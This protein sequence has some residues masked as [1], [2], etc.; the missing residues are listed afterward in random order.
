MHSA[1]KFY[2]NIRQKKEVEEKK[3]TEEAEK[4]REAGSTKKEEVASFA[5][6]A[7]K[8]KA[9]KDKTELQQ[10]ET[11]MVGDEAKFACDRCDFMGNTNRAVKLHW[12]KKHRREAQEEDDAKVKGKEVKQVE[13]KKL[14]EDLEKTKKDWQD[15]YDEDGNPLDEST[16]ETTLNESEMETELTQD[17]T[18]STPKTKRRQY[19]NDDELN[20]KIAELESLK[21][22]MK[23][24]EELLNI[25][26][27]KIASLEEQNI[28]KTEKIEKSDKIFDR[29]NEKMEE[30]KKN[31]K[32]DDPKLRKELNENNK[33]INN[34]NQRLSENLKKIRDESNL[35]AKAEADL[36][37]KDST[38]ECLKE[39]LAK[40]KSAS[41]Q[42][43]SGRTPS[44]QSS[45][46][47]AQ[48]RRSELCRDFQRHGFC[49]R[50]NKCIFFH[51]P[52]RNQP[53]CQPDSSMK[54]DC[55]YWLEGYCRKDEKQCRGKHDPAQCGTQAKQQP[56][57]S[58]QNPV[59]FNNQD[60]VQSLAKTVSQ[61]LVG[62][63]QGTT[64]PARGQQ[65]V[66]SQPQ[67]QMMN[68]QQN[69]MSNQANIIRNQQQP[70]MMPM[71]MMPNGQNM[72]FPAQQG[73]QAGQ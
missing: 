42:A 61:S 13:A 1:V 30:A 41:Q 60:F 4:L 34:L 24:K 57:Q 47:Q 6:L 45:R 16:A 28:K 66:G 10:F 55:R 62:G 54:P 68:I 73:R 17:I 15:M 32:G 50:G 53:S 5:K 27:A 48:E 51:P 39:I 22:L 44:P 64:A 7:A 40:H 70:I 14:K 38:I 69:T 18:T 35:R 56:R 29:I 37:T 33:E 59:N 9:Y 72:F 11:K 12:S 20:V 3:K 43:E 2:L 23:V 26:N 36:I 19:E 46:N 21:E 49:Y 25:A 31:K 71:M 8:V 63:Q 58:T 65:Q 67:D 52:G